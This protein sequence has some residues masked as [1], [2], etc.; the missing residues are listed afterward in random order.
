MIIA[1]PTE[2]IKE[3]KKKY[4]VARMITTTKVIKVIQGGG[5][6]GH[7]HIYTYIC[8]TYICAADIKFYSTPCWQYVWLT[9]LSRRA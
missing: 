3:I 9:D 8:S 4:K 2:N 6:T 7:T 1:I 5:I